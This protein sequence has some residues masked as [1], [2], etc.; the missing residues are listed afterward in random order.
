MASGVGGNVRESEAAYSALF[1]VA[2]RAERRGRLG[3]VSI[4]SL[5][6]ETEHTDDGRFR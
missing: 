2:R 5:V 3:F 6:D 1:E 4:G